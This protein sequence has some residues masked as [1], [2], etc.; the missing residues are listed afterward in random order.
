M[1][2]FSILDNFGQ[3]S[4]YRNYVLE[5]QDISK[6]ELYNASKASCNAN[7]HQIQLEKRLSKDYILWWKDL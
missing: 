1:S 5:W 2:L 6:F 7:P 3:S 4:L